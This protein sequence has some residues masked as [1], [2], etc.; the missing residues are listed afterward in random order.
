M[1]LCAFRGF[2]LQPLIWSFMVVLRSITWN[3]CVLDEGH[4]IKNTKTKVWTLDIAE[5]YICRFFHLFTQITKAVKQ[6]RANHR[7]ILSG[8]PIQ[9]RMY[10][11]GNTV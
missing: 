11:G 9:V 6:L 10:N 3:Y 4:I 5:P 8:T 1:V 7:L 2:F